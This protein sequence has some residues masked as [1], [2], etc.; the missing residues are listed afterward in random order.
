MLWCVLADRGVAGLGGL[1]GL[2]LQPGRAR[3]CRACGRVVVSVFC[4]ESANLSFLHA[5]CG[6]WDVAGER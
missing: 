1:L 4:V 5:P 6:C 3:R 2:L